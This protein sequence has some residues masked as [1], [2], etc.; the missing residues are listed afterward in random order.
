MNVQMALFTVTAVPP[1]LTYLDGTTVSAGM[2]TMIMAYFHLV[3]NHVKVGKGA[4]YLIWYSYEIVF[5]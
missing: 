2:V 5:E 3:E 1:V 4:S